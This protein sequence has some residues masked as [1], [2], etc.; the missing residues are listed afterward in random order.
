MS[1][2]TP[3]TLDPLVLP[4]GIGAPDAG[5][6]LRVAALG[7]VVCAEDC[8]FAELSPSAAELLPRWQQQTD[9]RVT[10]YVARIAGQ[11]TG[12][13]T[14]E[15][16]LAPDAD[17]VVF[18]L[19]VPAAGWGGGVQDVLLDSVVDDARRWRMP[20]LQTWTLHRP[21][22]PADRMLSPRTGWGTVTATRTTD[23]LTAHGFRL[24][25]VER[26]SAF[27]LHTDPALLRRRRD[28]AQRAAGPD[29][30]VVAW[31]PPTPAPWRAGYADLLARMDTD[32]PSGDLAVLAEAWD[33]HRVERRDSVFLDAGQLLSVVAVV[34]IPSGDL[35]AFNEL[36][37]GADRTETTQ[38]FG[39]LVRGDHRGRRLGMLVKCEGLLRW[40]QIVPL[41]AQVLTFNAEE[42]RPMLDV[43]EAL[44]FVAVSAAGGW[45]HRLQ[46]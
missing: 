41:S 3:I 32:V 36:V 34:H 7:R 8:G 18:D 9:H 33:D 39:T 43:N 1:A 13:V 16:S 45:Q 42:N 21:G 17:T 2:A 5:D 25:Q 27:D 28:E 20:L 31:S 6:F 10:G 11:I 14:M 19:L 23:L 40:Q 26:T 35:V 4:E 22:T 37:I 38:Q 24:E 30:R 12:A 44:G 15:V 46:L 29:Y